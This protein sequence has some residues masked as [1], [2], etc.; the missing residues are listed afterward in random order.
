MTRFATLSLILGL[1]VPAYAQ[2][3]GDNEQPPAPQPEPEPQPDPGAFERAVQAKK[4]KE[5]EERL[6]NVED[7][8]AQTKDDN[9]YLEE[10]LQ[11]LLPLT[12]K[13]SGYVDVGAFVTSGNGAGT[14]ADL[15]GVYFPEYAAAGV[16]GSWVF[17]GDPLSTMINSRGDVADTGESRAIVFDPINSQGN[18]TALV[19]AVNLALF[20]GIGETGSATVSID[21]LPRARDI[22]DVGGLFTGDFIDVK[23]AYGEWKP[24]LEKLDL[25]LQAGKFDSVVGFE[26][27]SLEAP[28]RLGVTPSLICRYTC[29]RPIGV[30]ARA[31][32]DGKLIANVAVTNGSHFMETF[33]FSNETDANQMKTV[34]GRLSYVF[35]DVFEIGASGAYGAQDLQPS[36][37]VTQWHVGGDVH[38]EYKG[39]D[40]TAEYVKG[41][42]S[43]DTTEGNLANCDLAPCLDYQGAYGLLGYRLTNT[44]IPYARVDWRDALHEKGADFVYI[45]DLMRVTAGIRAE[46]GTRVIA[47]IEGTLN[48]ELGRVPQFPNDV[49]TSSLVIKY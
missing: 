13:V 33:T 12:G 47:K 2:A 29:G 14:R 27:R 19:N 26:Y 8:L 10:K 11:A 9:T 24:R 41:K 49:V 35:K 37:D 42:A 25:A 28:D 31:K 34:A 22:S 21:F 18:S 48:R 30:K 7:E 5:L 46:I 39:I 3:P 15:A 38:L 32:I 45:S 17:M 23:L 44:F 6:S 20:S 16:P 40:F 1:G 36:D 43:G 4:L